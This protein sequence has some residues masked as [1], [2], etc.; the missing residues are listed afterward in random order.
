MTIKE[1]KKAIKGLPDHMDVLVRQYSDEYAFSMSEVMEVRD[2]SFYE[3]GDE[4]PED[5]VKVP[6]FVITDEL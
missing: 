5:A 4:D 1:L 6:C 2:I 3:S